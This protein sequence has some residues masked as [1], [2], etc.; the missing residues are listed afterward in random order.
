MIDY[1]FLYF[2]VFFLFWIFFID[3]TMR[4]R[5]YIALK[6]LQFIFSI[7]LIV[8]IGSNSYVN[9][10]AFGYAICFSIGIL[11]LY[12]MLADYIK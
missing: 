12:I 5:D 11:S 4:K 7:P 8:F 2:V 6:Y 3:L 10:F 1:N 9:S